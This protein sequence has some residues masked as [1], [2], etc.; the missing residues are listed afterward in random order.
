VTQ[1][2]RRTIICGGIHYGRTNQSGC[3]VGP[4]YALGGTDQR[5]SEPSGNYHSQQ[6]INLAA[7]IVEC[8]EM[9]RENST[10][11]CYPFE[12]IEALK[13]EYWL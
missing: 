1:L 12:M 13:E 5:M 7:R 8:L 9:S 4:P 10:A 2:F 6:G 3:T 11:E